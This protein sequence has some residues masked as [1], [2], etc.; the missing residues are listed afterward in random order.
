VPAARRCQPQPV[1]VITSWSSVPAALR[2]E[3]TVRD[4]PAL[5]PLMRPRWR[6]ELLYRTAA[7]A[8]ARCVRIAF[9]RP[10]SSSAWWKRRRDGARGDDEDAGGG[11]GS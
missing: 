7:S 5:R 11:R 10:T 3:L 9:S 6:D 1:R 8:T 4:S 2:P